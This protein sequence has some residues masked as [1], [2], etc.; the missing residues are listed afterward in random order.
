MPTGRSRERVDTAK[1]LRG[2]LRPMMT[3]RLVGAT[4]FVLL[5]SIGCPHTY[6][7]GGTLDRAVLKD[8]VENLSEKNC[9]ISELRDLCGEDGFE[10]CL[11]D[12]RSQVREG[13]RP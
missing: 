4:V 2:S 10:E 9:P 6:G 12:C 11:D 5:F 7:I 8:M 3:P 1:A 13:S